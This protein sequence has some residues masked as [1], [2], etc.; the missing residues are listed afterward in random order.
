MGGLTVASG[1]GA[2]LG[3]RAACVATPSL[4]LWLAAII[5]V[6]FGLL[7]ELAM[8]APHTAGLHI[9][10]KQ[11]GFLLTVA[12]GAA[13]FVRLCAWCIHLLR[14]HSEGNGAG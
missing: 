6:A 5:G 7:I 4:P 3:L 12:L 11:V 2:L 9:P 1:V 10:G 8:T 14:R 13:V